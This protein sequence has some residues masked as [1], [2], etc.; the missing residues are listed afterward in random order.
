MNYGMYQGRYTLKNALSYY[1]PVNYIAG[2]YLYFKHS[3]NNK[4]LVFE[5][6]SKLYPFSYASDEYTNESMNIILVV[7]E[8]AR[9]DHQSLNGYSRQTNPLLSKVDNLINF[10]NVA[11]IL[12]HSPME[13]L[14]M[15]CNEIYRL[16]IVFKCC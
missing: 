4:E 7:G 3:K 14:V 9:A 1:F 16:F 6:I 13:D 15:V 8:S 2:F 5:D 12:S 11:S 10:S